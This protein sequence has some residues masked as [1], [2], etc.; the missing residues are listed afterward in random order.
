MN[1]NDPAGKHGRLFLDHTWRNPWCCCSH[2]LYRVT[3]L[4]H[5]WVFRIVITVLS[6]HRGD[7]HQT[8]KEARGCL[9]YVAISS[10]A[11]SVY[12]QQRGLDRAVRNA[13]LA[14]VGSRWLISQGGGFGNSQALVGM[15][16][17][18]QKC[19]IWARASAGM[20]GCQG[21]SGRRIF[22]LREA[23]KYGWLW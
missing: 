3:R 2:F 11:W 22:N 20:P 13:G 7:G 4:R 5:Q 12:T 18:T 15:I 23:A 14:S 21:R 17:P 1:G 10:Q 9:L 8:P 19:P 6:V 16:R